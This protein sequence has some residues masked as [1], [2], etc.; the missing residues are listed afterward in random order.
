[1]NSTIREIK[2]SN[3]HIHGDNI[4]ECQRALLLIKEAFGAEKCAGP[5][6]SATC[7]VFRLKGNE[8]EDEI[9]CTF[10]PGFGR[11]RHDILSSIRDMGG[12]LREAADVIV[13][14]VHNNA[15]T[16]L[17]AIEFCGALPAG[18]QAW[19]RSGRAFSFG[20]AKVPYLY[21]SELGGFELDANRVRKAPRTPNPAVP[22]S[23]IAYS[24][25]HDTPVFPIFLTAPGADD[26]SRLSY[27][28]E[29]AEKELIDLIRA[30]ILDEDDKEIF[31]RLEQKVL[32][33]V[34]K[35]ALASR[36]GE[37]LSKRQWLS[38]YE[39]L[40]PTNRMPEYL[41]A[42][43][44][45]PWSKTA[46]IAALTERAKELMKWGARFGLGLT[47]T[48]L[49][50]SL[51]DSKARIKFAENVE[52]LYDELSDEFK[53]FLN[54]DEPLAICW[55]N[56]FKPRGDDARPD[57][58][59]PPLARMLIG[60]SHDLLT[61]VY[62]PAPAGTWTLLDRNPGA[63]IGRN[64]LWEVILETSDAVL[65]EAQT[66]TASKK[67]YTRAH[68]RSDLPQVRPRPFFVL[69]Q[70]TKLGENDVDT[71]LHLLLAHL[72]GEEV[73]EGMCN[74]PGGDWSGVSILDGD[75]QNQLR[76]I[77]LPRV[78]GPDTKRP[79]HVF[80]FFSTNGA[81]IVLSVESKEIP[82]TLEAG[83]GPRLTAYLHYLFS[84]PASIQADLVGGTWRHSTATV[85]LPDFRFASA[86]AFIATSDVE[87]K[88]AV[89]RA[90]TDLCFS[91]AFE[92]GGQRCTIEVITSTLLGQ[93]IANFIKANLLPTELINLRYRSEV[94]V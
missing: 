22:F 61:I 55:V 88:S 20:A 93:E 36:A 14:G 58:G 45:Q 77:S 19:Q 84:S 69:P 26:S 40:S 42:Q 7:P 29:F 56:G 60:A 30:R 41:L 67:G 94:Q 82:R 54:K 9:V 76:W 15:E 92:D 48:K 86:G 34:E 18:N 80:Q 85:Q 62:G 46:Y 43:V 39:S 31:E 1:M 59:L 28:E 25:E 70:P 4:V 50:M 91:V 3:L 51:L 68:W 44:R 37:T 89:S 17:F 11:W 6:V 2:Y 81:P 53:A 27:A 83:I 21:V 73:F 12:T 90:D 5:D 87:V 57:R 10:F 47:S 23:Y 13:T 66:D 24:K 52:S 72:L 38:A 49:P 71:A 32:S 63:L 8:Y 65:V 35:K 33:F 16:P 74:P 75:R 64:G 79:D 78:S